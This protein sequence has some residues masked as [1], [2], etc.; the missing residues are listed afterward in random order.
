MKPQENNNQKTNSNI[1]I[2]EIFRDTIV[3]EGARYKND[4]VILKKVKRAI[5]TLKRVGYIKG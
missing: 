2:P 1:N 5:D 3:Y 4:P